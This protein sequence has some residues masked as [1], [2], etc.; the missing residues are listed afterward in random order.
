V[1]LGIPVFPQR[2]AFLG[3]GSTVGDAVLAEKTLRG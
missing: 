3:K 1:T 2:Q